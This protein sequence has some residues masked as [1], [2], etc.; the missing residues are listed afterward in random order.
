MNPYFKKAF[1][2]LIGIEGGY[3][4]DPTDRGGE[5][6]YGISKRSYPHLD[7]K[8]LTLQQA[9]EIYYRDFWKAN[10]LDNIIKYELALE[11]FDT[12]VNMGVGVAPRF[13]QE[14]L[15]LMNRNQRDFPDLVVDG[16]IGPVS[17]AA[18]KKVDDRI[19]LKVLNGLQFRRYVEICEKR[20]DQEKYF[21]GWM[22]RV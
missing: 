5:T 16:K 9:E 6:K 7:I 19:L 12:G 22:K 3:V 14:A 17:I 21:N 1:I 8:N 11:L 15:N 10:G 2:E 20:P 13:L 18:Y 4:N